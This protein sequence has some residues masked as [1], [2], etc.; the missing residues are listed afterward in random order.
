MKTFIRDII[1]F[2]LLGL[3]LSEF[4]A[5]T[6]YLTVD[7]PKR[8]IDQYGIQKY[9]PNQTGSWKNNTHKWVINELGWAG[10]LPKSY[11]QLV[12]IIGDSYIENFMN[13]NECRQ[14]NYLKN[15]FPNR[16][17]LEAGRAGVSFI[18]AME[19]T[20]QFESYNPVNQ[21]IYV[22]GNDFI[23]SVKEIKPLYDITQLS[24]DNKEVI[25]GRMKSSTLKNT[26]YNWKFIFYLYRRFPLANL[27]SIFNKKQSVEEK[28]TKN[29]K[30]AIEL[31]KIKNL[32]DFVVSNYEIAGKTLVFHPSTN[33]KII[34][35]VKAVGFDVIILD[36]DDDNKSW[37]FEYDNHWNCYGH[38][39]VA[40]QVATYLNT[41]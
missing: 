16:N 15:R 26:L 19:I 23:E 11:D 10:K 33:I 34:Q 40:K 1:V 30:G 4:I 2:A 22:S 41:E 7:I 9:V 24:I 13:P 17:F 18:E 3:C 37:T 8:E 28:V 20:K 35:K 29:E 6:T 12:T 14:K 27:K 39:Q 5:R 38:E 36:D 21:L 32:L 25:P 31:K